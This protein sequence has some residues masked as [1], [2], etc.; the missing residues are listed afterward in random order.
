MRALIVGYGSI[1]QRHVAVLA[2]MGLD[3]A[4]VSRREIDGITR[5]PDLATALDDWAPGYVVIAS[6]TSEH[7]GDLEVVAAS[8]YDGIL[9]VEK[10]ALNDSVALP[11]DLPDRSFVAFNLRFHPAV[12]AMRET[13]GGAPAFSMHA[14]VG[15]Y[16]PDWRPGT[17]YRQSY[18]AQKEIGGGV[19]RDLCH[20][21][22]LANWLFGPWMQL[23]AAG[24]HLSNL[25]I[26]SDDSFSLLIEMDLCPVAAISMNYLDKQVTRGMTV[27]AEAGTFKIDL[28]NATFTANEKSE[29]YDVGRNDTYIAEHQAILN[30]R[31]DVLCRLDQSA[32]VMGMILAAERASRD[33]IWIRK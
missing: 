2:D 31:T 28:V 4:V 32:D 16:L 20:E 27:H 18:S 8:G 10:P 12:Q 25:E 3:V 15:Q 22:D 33:R 29:R 9:L 6:R 14:Y 13:L 11:R 5:Y 1:G 21:L 7:L 23:T 17:D 26:D 30:D 19:L 24:G